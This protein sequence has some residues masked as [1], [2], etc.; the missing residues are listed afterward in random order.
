MLDHLLLNVSAAVFVGC[1]CN[2]ALWPWDEVFVA[3]PVSRTVSW[4]AIG[5]GTTSE[6]R[7]QNDRR[8]G[9]LFQL[10]SF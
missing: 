10:G 9:G 8:E 3:F 5:L 4:G 1:L 6:G 7:A 2:P